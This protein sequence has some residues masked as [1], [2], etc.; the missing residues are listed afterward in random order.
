PALLVVGEVAALAGSLHWFG[1]P[2]L[3]DDTPPSLPAK[4]MA[5]KLAHAA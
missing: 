3:R 5:P 2:P 4:T 1:Q